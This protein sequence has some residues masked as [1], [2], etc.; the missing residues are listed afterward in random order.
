MNDNNFF[1][2][3]TFV[4]ILE[5]G[6]KLYNLQFGAILPRVLVNMSN[7]SRAVKVLNF[8]IRSR[9]ITPEIFKNGVFSLKTRRMFCTK[10]KIWGAF[11]LIPYKDFTK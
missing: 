8:Q 1:F 4:D 10:C 6:T 11:F 9:H 3:F 5:T 7:T 2:V